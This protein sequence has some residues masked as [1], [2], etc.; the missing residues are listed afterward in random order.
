MYDNIYKMGRKKK[1]EGE[2]KT[3]ESVRRAVK[4][5]DEKK[6]KEREERKIFKPWDNRAKKNIM[7]DPR[8]RSY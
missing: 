6:R 4:K 7:I 2:Y 5:Y 8:R 1:N 3:P